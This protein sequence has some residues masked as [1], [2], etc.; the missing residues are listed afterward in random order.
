MTH[1]FREVAGWVQKM[2]P[3]EMMENL[4]FD[5]MGWAKETKALVESV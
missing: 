3:E 4:P 2:S 1:L 5:G